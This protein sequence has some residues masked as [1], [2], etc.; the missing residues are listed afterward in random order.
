METLASIWAHDPKDLHDLDEQKH[1]PSGAWDAQRVFNGSPPGGRTWTDQMSPHL[2]RNKQLQDTLLQREEELARLQEE[3]IRLREFLSS[4]F[5]KNLQQNAKKLTT[6]QRT[7]LKRHL[8]YSDDKPSQ[9]CSHQPPTS[10]QASKRVCR[11]L[12]AQFC[13][14]SSETS[15]CPEPKLD[16]WVLR[17]LGLKDRDTIDTSNEFPSE[18]NLRGLVCDAASTLFLSP[19][20]TPD[21]GCSNPATSTGNCSGSVEDFT[22]AGLNRSYKSHEAVIGTYDTSTAS[23]SNRPDI[24]SITALNQVETQQGSSPEQPLYWSPVFDDR[25]PTEQASFSPMLSWSSVTDQ[26][27]T[28]VGGHSLISPSAASSQPPSTPQTPRRPTDLAFSMS[29]SPSSSV[30]THSFPQGQ[31]FIRRDPGGRWNFTWVPTQQP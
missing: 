7:T 3:N 26:P 9:I 28:P 4:S 29:L 23:R 31:A 10:R 6:K 8:T 30:K 15:S 21:T 25:T 13:S 18:Y 22:A 20:Y 27:W 1:K 16:L 19:E 24:F 14:E 17:T 11:N 12:T 5:V 2:Q